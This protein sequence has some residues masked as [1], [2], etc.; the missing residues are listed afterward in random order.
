MTTPSRNNY[1]RRHSQ[2]DNAHRELL[3]QWEL[4]HVCQLFS[5]S[6]EAAMFLQRFSVQQRTTASLERFFDM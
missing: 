1:K 6:C 4:S 2:L 3:M 5:K